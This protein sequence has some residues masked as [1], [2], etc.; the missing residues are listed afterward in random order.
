MADS[1]DTISLTKRGE[2]YAAEHA[3][4]PETVTSDPSAN[5][6]QMAAL[7]PYGCPPG[8][9][10]AT[11]RK[12]VARRIERHLALVSALVAALDV[13]DGD[14]DLEDAGDAEPLLGWPNAG[15]RI[16]E[17]MAD[18]EDREI[19]DC[20][21]EPSLASVETRTG[22]VDYYAAQHSVFVSAPPLGSQERWAVGGMND[23]ENEHDGAEP[24]NEHGPSWMESAALQGRLVSGSDEGDEP[25]L[26]LTEHVNQATR[27]L[28]TKG[29]HFD[30]HEA[31]YAIEPGQGC[32]RARFADDEPS[33]GSQSIRTIKGAV[34]HDPEGIENGF[35]DGMD[36]G[37]AEPP[38]EG[39]GLTPL[40]DHG[41]RRVAMALIAAHRLA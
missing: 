7:R 34:I 35:G 29:W 40:G 21:W 17:E 14:A 30:D 24:E 16:T 26:G 9:D 25:S 18:D 39:E 11:W 1:A 6:S 38:A 12:A 22:S 37:F 4:S 8:I 41:G 33:G 2:R 23:R 27:L 3:G 10:A 32:G 20:D 31:D 19:D 15:Q 13:V 36:H 28:K 5:A